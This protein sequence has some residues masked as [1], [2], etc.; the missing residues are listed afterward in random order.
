MPNPMQN[1]R[2]LAFDVDGVL[3]D[4]KLYID[5]EG[6]ELHAFHI[7][8]GMG[9]ALAR[10]QGLILVAISGRPSGGVRARLSQL[11]VHEIHLGIAK[12]MAKLEEILQKHAIPASQCCYVGDDV[13]DVEIMA[14]VGQSFAP[15][16][17]H[18][19][20]L[21]AAK[22]ITETKGGQG[23]LR[24]IIDLWFATQSS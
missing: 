9:M 7:H 5:E 22:N 15:A 11:G 13:N 20:A 12:K 8:D 23:V 1:I 14:A 21:A 16:D 18:K 17:A 4:A 2:L 6:R 24:E 3:T 10:K 19:S